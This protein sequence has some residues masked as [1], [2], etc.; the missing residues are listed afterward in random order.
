MNKYRRHK[1]SV[2]MIRTISDSCTCCIEQID[3][4]LH[5]VIDAQ[6]TSQR[7]KN[8]KSGPRDDVEWDTDVL[9][10]L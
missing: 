2:R 7:G 4:I 5:L 9:N 8:K 3:S 6:M 1:R 10:T